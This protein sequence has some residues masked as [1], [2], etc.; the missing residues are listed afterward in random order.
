MAGGLLARR[1]PVEDVIHGGVWAKVPTKDTPQ[2]LISTVHFCTPHQDPML[3]RLR[4]HELS[5]PKPKHSCGCRCGWAR[6]SWQVP[7]STVRLR[8]IR[9][10]HLHQ[11]T[12]CGLT[13]LSGSLICPTLANTLISVLWSYPYVCVCF[14]IIIYYYYYYLGSRIPWKCTRWEKKGTYPPRK[15]K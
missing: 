13:C 10:C 14:I 8:A 15:E 12:P 4:H 7:R 5:V 1:Q 9:A 3:S 11:R 2:R 6:P